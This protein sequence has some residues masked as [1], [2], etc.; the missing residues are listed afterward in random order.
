[1]KEIGGY[2]GLENFSGREF[3]S[4]LIGLNSARNALAYLIRARKIKKIYIPKYLCD[5][6]SNVCKREHCDV[7]YYDIDR[8]FLPVLDITLNRNDEFIYIV[9]YFGQLDNETILELNKKYKKIIV[10]NVQAFFQRPLENVDTIFSCRKYFGVP[11]GGYLSTDACLSLERDVSKNRMKHILGRFEDDC[12]HVFYQDFRQSE[13]EIDTLD[14]RMMSSITKNILNAVN[15]EEIREKR[16]RNF[17][18]LLRAFENDNPL[19]IKAPVGPYAF[20]LYIKDGQRIKKELAK[21]KIY[22]PTLWTEA[23]RFGGV[24]KDYSENIL[25][26]P[27]DQRYTIE[28]MFRIVEEIN[29]V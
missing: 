13:L 2:F 6:V 12:A 16:E 9:N 8:T 20:P 18:V 5:S 15:Y 17:R 23:I 3:Y 4:D 1:M 11:D 27:C 25:P 14:L 29:N 10:D 19:R 28:D 26:L 7:E 21:K 24:A 22:I